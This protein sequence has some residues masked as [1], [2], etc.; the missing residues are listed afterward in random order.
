MD[1][2]ERVL[3]AVNHQEPDRLP[4][5]LWG[6]AYGM[7]DPLYR[8]LLEYLNVGQP[9]LPFRTRRGHT[10]NYYDDRVLEALDTDVRY[11]WLGFTDLGGPPAGSGLDAPGGGWEQKGI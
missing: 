1:H 11:V 7:T 8:E 3:V 6:S 4:T 2:R 9:V 5:A 10:V